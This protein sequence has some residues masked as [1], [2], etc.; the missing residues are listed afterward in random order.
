MEE[1]DDSATYGVAKSWRRA[2]DHIDKLR[3]NGVSPSLIIT[4]LVGTSVVIKSY[5]EALKILGNA[6]QYEAW[7]KDTETPFDLPSVLHHLIFLKPSE[8]T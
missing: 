6:Y 7:C 3:E 1:I 5:E 8:G 2:R 4:K